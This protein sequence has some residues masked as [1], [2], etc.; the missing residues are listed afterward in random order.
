VSGPAPVVVGLSSSPGGTA[1]LDWAVAEAKLR[2]TPLVLAYAHRGDRASQDAG[3]AVLRRARAHGRRVPGVPI[4]TVSSAATPAE[5]LSRL[6]ATACLVVVGGPMAGGV[7]AVR[8]PTCLTLAARCHAPVAVVRG[9]HG[10]AEALDWPVVAAVRSP[11]ADREVIDYAFAMARREGRPLVAVHA[12]GAAAVSDRER[13][14]C[15]SAITLALGRRA[16]AHPGV[17]TRAEVATDGAD[18]AVLERSA[19]AAVLVLGVRRLRQRRGLDRLPV[20]P[21][22]L[23]RVGPLLGT[24][25]LEEVAAFRA[26]CPVVLVPPGRAAGDG[27]A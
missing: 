3:T 24:A 22:L 26:R 4:S 20:V 2:G 9:D 16:G 19:H 14:R 27:P 25:P 6:S 10:R 1:V 7:D 8:G 11:D 12:S 17:L 15:G 23:A 5:L 21:G 18:R 13:A